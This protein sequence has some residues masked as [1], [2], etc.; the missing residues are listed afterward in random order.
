MGKITRKKY[1]PE[2]K[3]KVALA[4]IREEGTLAELALRYGLHANQISKWKKEAI[5]GLKARFA[6]DKASS[7]RN[8]EQITAPL[9]KQIGEL[10]VELGFL[11][12]KSGF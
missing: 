3:A 11:R 2:F 1:S 12:R 6:G 10:T 5:E 9:Y 4:A 7:P 8:E